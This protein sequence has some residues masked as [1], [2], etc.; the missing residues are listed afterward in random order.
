M[1]NEAKIIINTVLH[2]QM[3]MIFL[4]ISELRTLT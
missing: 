4:R 1:M 3:Q 2:Q